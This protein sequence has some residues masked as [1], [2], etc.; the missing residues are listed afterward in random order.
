[1]CILKHFQCTSYSKLESLQVNSLTVQA[2]KQSA[3]Q[4]HAS[5]L[6]DLTGV[7]TETDL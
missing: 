6:L 5:N 2:I 1:M 4:S 7:L 3:S